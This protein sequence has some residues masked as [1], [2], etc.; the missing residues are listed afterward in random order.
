[1]LLYSGIL[2][3]IKIIIK[4]LLR[5]RWLFAAVLGN[6]VAKRF[7]FEGMSSLRIEK[8]REPLNLLSKSILLK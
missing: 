1:V 8:I 7:F 4:D 5:S 2:K 3:G 6:S